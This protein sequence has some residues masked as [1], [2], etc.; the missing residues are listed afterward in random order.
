MCIDSLDRLCLRGQLEESFQSL[1][2]LGSFRR[3]VAANL[4]HSIAKQ[5]QGL[6][7]ANPKIGGAWLCKDIVGLS[8]S[9]HDLHV[10]AYTALSSDSLGPKAT[11][12]FELVEYEVGLPRSFWT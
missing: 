6:A 7:S 9:R 4:M 10:L 2:A 5:G 11:F 8:P 3:L 12:D 1:H